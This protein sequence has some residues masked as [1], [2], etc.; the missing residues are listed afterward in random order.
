MDESCAIFVFLDYFCMSLIYYIFLRIYILKVQTWTALML[1]VVNLSRLTNPKKSKN[2]TKNVST[3]CIAL[4]SMLKSLS[5]NTA[6][7]P[8]NPLNRTSWMIWDTLFPSF[9]WQPR[10]FTQ[11]AKL[12]GNRSA[13]RTIE[14]IRVVP[15][16]MF[17]HLCD[18]FD[19]LNEVHPYAKTFI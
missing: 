4:K 14:G 3:Y 15:P 1:L 19:V 18:L 7:T 11:L 16:C 2:T 6:R 12:E 17:D 5:K 13:F 8:S 10:H 9:S